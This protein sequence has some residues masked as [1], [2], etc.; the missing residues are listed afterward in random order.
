MVAFLRASTAASCIKGET[1][2]DVVSNN[3]VIFFS[4]IAGFSARFEVFFVDFTRESIAAGK[5]VNRH[6]E[7][8]KSM[9]CPVV[10][11]KQVFLHKR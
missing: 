1:Q 7:P 9:H 2:D 11:P 5:I 4:Q 10:T 8:H 6:E 3:K